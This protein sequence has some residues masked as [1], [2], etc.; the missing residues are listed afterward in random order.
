MPNIAPRKKTEPQRQ[1]AVRL[2]P[3]LFQKIKN[4]S[5]ENKMS[6][7]GQIVAMLQSVAFDAFTKPTST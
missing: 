1:I 2:P 7:S 4:L 5:R 6:I 3:A